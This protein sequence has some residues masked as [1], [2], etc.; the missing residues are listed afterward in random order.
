MSTDHQILPDLDIWIRAFGRL[1]PDPR[2]VH[3][4]R[5]AVRARQVLS[6]GWIRQGLLAR[7]D[8]ERQATRLEW[9][10]SGYPEVILSPDDPVHAANLM[11]RLRGTGVTLAG[12][13]ALLWTIAERIG[14]RIWSLD[15]RWQAMERHGAPIESGMTTNPA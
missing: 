10:L 2:V 4:F 15:R 3:A 14:A 1:D 8:D 6:V 11:R 7:L 9:I 12:P 5:E 13:A